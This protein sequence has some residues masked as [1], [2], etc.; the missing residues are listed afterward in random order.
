TPFVMEALAV[1]AGGG[2]GPSQMSAGVECVKRLYETMHH[3]R[4]QRLVQAGIAP[5]LAH[6]MSDLHTPNFM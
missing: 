2:A 6:K 1:L 4:V 3:N 5:D